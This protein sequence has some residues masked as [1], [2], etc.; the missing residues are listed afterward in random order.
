MNS[1]V[2]KIRNLVF[3]FTGPLQTRKQ[4][5]C[6]GL[7]TACSSIFSSHSFAQNEKLIGKAPEMRASSVDQMRG[8]FAQFLVGLTQKQYGDNGLNKAY[9][10]GQDISENTKI[11]RTTMP[12]YSEDQKEKERV[13]MLWEHIRNDS[14]RTLGEKV[15]RENDTIQ[16]IQSGFKFNVD[17]SPSSKTSLTNANKQSDSQVKYGLVL[18]EIVKKKEGQL[19]AALG[20]FDDNALSEYAGTSE[21][22]WT[23]GPLS[24]DDRATIQPASIASEQ[25]NEAELLK[26]FKIPE[27]KF[28][29]QLLPNFDQGKSPGAKLSVIQ[30]QGLYELTTNTGRSSKSDTRHKFKLPLIGEMNIGRQLDHRF[31]VVETSLNDI[32]VKPNAP[33][34]SLHYLNKE[35]RY[36]ADANY[37]IRSYALGFKAETPRGWEPS[38][39]SFMKSKGE[40]Y[41]VSLAKIF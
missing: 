2:N 18:K 26:G 16:K 10:L 11:V 31:E 38:Q 24:E 36:T 39:N 35:D 37:S 14:S 34:V 7:F 28:G 8:Q 6:F 21:A 12:G 4:A 13:K 40:K 41:E 15:A 3:L 5:L 33:K 23:I 17:L 25:S 20:P 32:L 29:A 30:S 9:L 22:I 19:Q 1:S 27:A